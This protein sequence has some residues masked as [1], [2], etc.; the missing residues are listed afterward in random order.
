VKNVSVPL[1]L[2]ITQCHCTSLFSVVL[3]CGVTS[4]CCGHSKFKL[5]M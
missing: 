3:C 5:H 2:Y 4:R 1:L